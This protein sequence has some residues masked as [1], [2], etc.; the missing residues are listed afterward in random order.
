MQGGNFLAPLSCSSSFL[1]LPFPLFPNVK[2]FLGMDSLLLLP[3]LGSLTAFFLHFFIFFVFLLFPQLCCTE[4]LSCPPSFLP[5][6]VPKCTPFFLN[7]LFLYGPAH[8]FPWLSPA[9]S[10]LSWLHSSSLPSFSLQLS[11]SPPL[12]CFLCC[13]GTAGD[14]SHTAS[15]AVHHLPSLL[16]RHHLVK[17]GWEG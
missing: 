2:K 6:F 15:R 8:L 14:G 3:P 5:F 7:F 1:S 9:S 10:C 4:L 12:P 13:R 11:P 16:P 17:G